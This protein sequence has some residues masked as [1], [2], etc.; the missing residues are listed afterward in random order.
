MIMI[1]LQN[2]QFAVDYLFWEDSIIQQQKLFPLI[3]VQA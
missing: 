3:Y 2:V 1:I